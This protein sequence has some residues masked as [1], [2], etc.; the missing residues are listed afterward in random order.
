MKTI[1]LT[2]S[3]RTTSGKGFS[4]RARAAGTMPAIVY[5]SDVKPKQIQVGASE[6]KKLSATIGQ[7]VFITLKLDGDAVLNGK[8]VRVREYQ[9]H[10]L[11]HHLIHTDFV[12]VDLNKSIVVEVEL[13]LVGRPIGLA[14]QGILNHVRREIEVRCLPKDIP[15]K[16]EIDV[17]GLDLNESL[18][19][20]DVKM[21]ANVKAV[22][23]DNYTIASVTATR[24]EAVKVVETAVVEGAPAAGAAAAGAAPGAAGAKGAAPAAAGD[25]KAGD[26][27]GGAKAPAA[28]APAG[29]K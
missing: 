14:K 24:E 23:T 13:E 18:H 1:D 5:G 19:I 3:A 16:I 28:K 22:F 11:K 8:T 2:V 25:A 10:P 20:S 6:I 7:N 12:T 26:A 9:V 15:E 29:K 27:K 17:A 21:P 4:R